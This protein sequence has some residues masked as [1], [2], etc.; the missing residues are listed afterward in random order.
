M[1]RLGLITFLLM[2]TAACQLKATDLPSFLN[3]WELSPALP[4]PA[5]YTA[6]N[7]ETPSPAAAA[8]IER[9]TVYAQAK[10]YYLQ[11]E[12]L[13]ARQLMGVSGSVPFPWIIVNSVLGDEAKLA[14]LVHELGHMCHGDLPIRATEREIIAESVALLVL[15][16]APGIHSTR[17]SVLYILEMVPAGM[18]GPLYTRQAALIQSCADELRKVRT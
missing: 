4:T 7:T 5:A 2:A 17:Y 18:R 9:F 11:F 8:L 6:W 13:T 16:D 1:R 12:D 10:T 14:T 15:H 3:A